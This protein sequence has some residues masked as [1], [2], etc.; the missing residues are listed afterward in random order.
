MLKRS[1]VFFLISI[2][3]AATGCDSASTCTT[4]CGTMVV[5]LNSEPDAILPVFAQSSTGRTLSALL[6]LSLAEIGLDL[7][8]VA[9]EGFEPR[10]ARSWSFVDSLT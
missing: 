5:N 4:D 8:V 1:T 7:G 2:L 10:L 3:V 6:F 9:D